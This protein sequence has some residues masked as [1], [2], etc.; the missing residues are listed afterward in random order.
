AVNQATL[1]A[2]TA[3]RVTAVLRDV[4]QPVAAGE[5]LVRLSVVEQQAGADSARAVLR[6][7]EAAAVEA[8]STFQRYQALSGERF[9]SKAQLD[10]AR[11]MR[12][13]ARAAV[14]AARAQLAEAS[15]QA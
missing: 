7:A 11:A 6:A 13:S 8:E 14:D 3:G 1:S 15:Q 9:V 5:V 2:Q 4:N 12:D 10:Q